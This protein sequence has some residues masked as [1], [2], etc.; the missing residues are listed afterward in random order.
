MEYIRK[1]KLRR[2]KEEKLKIARYCFWCDCYIDRKTATLDHLIPQALWGTDS[3][4]NIVLSCKECNNIR[5]IITIKY[6]TLLKPNNIP[7]KWIIGVEKHIDKIRM[8]ENKYIKIHN[9]TARIHCIE[10]L[11]LVLNYYESFKNKPQV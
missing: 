8:F 11:K 3:P 10:E 9:Y 1:L 5:G 7:E 2:I 6:K 4:G